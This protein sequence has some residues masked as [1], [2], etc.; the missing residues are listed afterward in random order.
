[1]KNQNEISFLIIS[2]NAIGD[3]YLSLS[4]IH[5]IKNTFPNSKIF[6]VINY[7]SNLLSPFIPVDEIFILK[8]RSVFSVIN[9]LIKLRKIQFD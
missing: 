5:P 6:L 2:T 7:D 4:A 3:S 9:L 8:S 1:M